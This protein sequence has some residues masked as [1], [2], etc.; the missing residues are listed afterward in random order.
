MYVV[1]QLISTQPT[2]SVEEQ[3]ILGRFLRLTPS[4]FVG[5][6]SE[7]TFEFLITCEDR[8]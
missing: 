5:D 6:L 1:A 8:L 3:N 2:M 7:D 4:R